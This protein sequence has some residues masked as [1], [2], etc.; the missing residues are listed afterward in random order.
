MAK[1]K[2]NKRRDYNLSSRDVIT[3]EKS[4]IPRQTGFMILRGPGLNA[5]EAIEENGLMRKM[6]IKKRFKLK[7][8]QAMALDDVI[9]HFKEAN[10]WASGIVYNLGSIT[11]E[12]Q[13]L[14]KTID[15]LLIPTLEIKEDGKETSLVEGLEK[16]SSRGSPH[17]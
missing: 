14:K 8:M 15:R 2:V 3:Y 6:G 1:K 10:T 5:T 4:R 16:M 12:A 9:K 13:A 17:G 11:D 7:F